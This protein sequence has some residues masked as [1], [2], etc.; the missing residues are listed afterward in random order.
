MFAKLHHTYLRLGHRLRVRR[1]AMEEAWWRLR[2]PQDAPRQ[3]PSRLGSLANGLQAWCHETWPKFAHPFRALGDWTRARTQA[4]Q[5]LAAPLAAAAEHSQRTTQWRSRWWDPLALWLRVYVT[6]RQARHLRLGLP[7]LA[8]LVVFTGVALV[9]SGIRP[10]ATRYTQLLAAAELAMAN[11][12]YPKALIAYQRMLQVGHADAATQFRLA[13]C[14]AAQGQYQR[15]IQLLYALAPDDTTGYL[16]AH[17]VR[18]F[19]ILQA[20]QTTAADLALARRH[21]ERVLA[22][23][24]E[25]HEAHGLL[26]TLLLRQ[27]DT[28]GARDQFVQSTSG[29]P[30]MALN[31]ALLSRELGDPKGVADNAALAVAYYQG[32]LRKMDKEAPAN[33]VLSLAQALCLQNNYR[34][35]IGTLESC[36][37][38]SDRK[39]LGDGILQ[40]C[41]VWQQEIERRKSAEDLDRMF[42]ANS[43]LAQQPQSREWQLRLLNLTT[44]KSLVRPAALQLLKQLAQ[45]NHAGAEACFFLG[46]EAL[47]REDYAVAR[48]HLERSNELLPGHAATLNNLTCALLA[49]PNPDPARALELATQAVQAA[50][51]NALFRETRGEALLAA[52]RWAE[53]AAELEAVLPALSDRRQAHRYLAQAYDQLGM[54]DQ[55]RQQRELALT[56][57]HR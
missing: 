9:V 28:P 13:R 31:A 11:Q 8:A 48:R 18:A 53:A 23:N 29:R 12:D 14:L 19:L 39:P 55:A 22:A 16:P 43:A 26:A 40:I 50:P 35:A 17:R 56:D 27:K 4:L 46:M 1:Q 37:D 51:A 41:E 24:P 2:K 32:E 3:R 49:G 44:D 21:L 20:P 34:E 47:R 33:T 5:D 30:D 15:A 45:E 6:T 7:A 38:R 10:A 36:L 42:I 25:D 54:P 57:H 52:G